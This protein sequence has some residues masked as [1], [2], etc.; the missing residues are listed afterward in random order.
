MDSNTGPYALM[1]AHVCVHCGSQK[2][3]IRGKGTHVRHFPLLEVARHPLDRC[4]KALSPQQQSRSKR[5]HLCDRTVSS[6]SKH[7]QGNEATNMASS[8]AAQVG[9]TEKTNVQQ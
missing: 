8:P 2:R 3:N 4:H 9:S 5:Q 1:H 6:A 7:S